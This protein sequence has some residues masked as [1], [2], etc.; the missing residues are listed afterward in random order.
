MAELDVALLDQRFDGDGDAL[1]AFKN[2]AEYAV[3][4]DA[5]NSEC[6]AHQEVLA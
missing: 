1:E 6:L 2:T 3:L 4:R 5:K